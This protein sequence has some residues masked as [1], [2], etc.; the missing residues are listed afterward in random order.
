LLRCEEETESTLVALKEEISLGNTHLARIHDDLEAAKRWYAQLL[1]I[2]PYFQRPGY[3]EFRIG[4]YQ[5]ELG[6][7]DSKY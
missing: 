7:I 5:H 3:Y 1:G 4:D 6:L 2:E